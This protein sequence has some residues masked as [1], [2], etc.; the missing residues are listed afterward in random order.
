M[1][2]C[3]SELFALQ[4]TE[5]Q[6]YA[7]AIVTAAACKL[8]TSTQALS[9]S[10]VLCIGKMVSGL[11]T[12]ALSLFYS[13]NNLVHTSHLNHFFTAPRIESYSCGTLRAF[14]LLQLWSLHSLQLP[15][16]PPLFEQCS[17]CTL[18]PLSLLS[19]CNFDLYTPCDFQSPILHSACS[20]IP[21]IIV[22]LNS[23]VQLFLFMS[24]VTCC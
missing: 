8:R 18:P 13:I 4:E 3:F 11:D 15:V 17:C 16:P 19:C 7:R 24:A 6:Q 23:F 9:E 2:C 14:F 5:R 22:V 21:V 1:C 12:L 20:Y 10:Q